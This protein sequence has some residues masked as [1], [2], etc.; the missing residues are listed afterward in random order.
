MKSE[1][2]FSKYKS[3]P[4]PYAKKLKSQ[5]TIRLRNDAIDYFKKMAEDTGVPYQNL[6]DSYLVD[7]A[8]HKRKLT[9]AW[10]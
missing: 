2:D 9:M 5:V 10:N 6:I 4:N 8:V 1:Y 3:R 7:C